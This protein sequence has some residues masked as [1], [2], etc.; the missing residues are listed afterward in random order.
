MEMATSKQSK[1]SDVKET[2]LPQQDPST[3]ESFFILHPSTQWH[4]KFARLCE[5]NP[6]PEGFLGT[7]TNLDVLIA[8]IQHVLRPAFGPKMLFTILIPNETSS[9]L[10][11]P[12]RKKGDT[13]LLMLPRG[14]GA[15]RFKSELLGTGEPS[16]CL[17]LVKL[18]PATVLEDIA[19]R[20]AAKSKSKSRFSTVAN[21]YKD[22]IISTAILGSMVAYMAACA[23]LLAVPFVGVPLACSAWLSGAPRLITGVAKKLKGLDWWKVK[24]RILGSG[25]VRLC[26]RE[27]I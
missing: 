12:Q 15:L 23:T 27:E 24:V 4:P 3:T 22:V 7:F 6:L 2:S 25:E 11:L 21:C 14:I 13:E 17:D 20:S 5:E 10:L 18:E 16:L 8:L 1:Y 9:T 19:L 26:E